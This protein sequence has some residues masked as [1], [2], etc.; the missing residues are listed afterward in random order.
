MLTFNYPQTKYLKKSFEDAGGALTSADSG[1]LS[2][3][4]D[5]LSICLESW[6][7]TDNTSVILIFFFNKDVC[8]MHS[9]DSKD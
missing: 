6:W 1:G 3:D 8:R 7:K 2:L 9:N 4:P 5:S